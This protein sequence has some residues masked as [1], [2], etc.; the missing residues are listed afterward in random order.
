[1]SRNNRNKTEVVFPEQTTSIIES[2]L[3]KYG[4]AETEEEMFQK[5]MAGQTSITAL[6]AQLVKKMA[7]KIVSFEELLSAFQENVKLPAK[8]IE[9]LAQDIKENIVS[10]AEE[11]KE[12]PPPTSLQHQESPPSSKES[13]ETKENDIYREPIA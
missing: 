7:L 2:T 5:I 13:R 6:T 4:L 8:Q 11:I 9:K 1:M 12:E 10:L 3:A